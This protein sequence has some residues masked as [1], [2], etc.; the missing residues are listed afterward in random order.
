MGMDAYSCSYCIYIYFPVASTWEHRASAKR[1]VSLQFLNSKTVG[2]T[3]WTR[4]QPVARPPPTQTQNQR[5]HTSMPWVGF[6]STIPVLK[7]VQVVQALDRAATVIGTLY[8]IMDD[9]REK[10]GISDRDTSRW[11]VYEVEKFF[12]IFIATCRGLFVWLTGFGLDVG[13]INTLYTRL[14]LQATQRYRCST[15]CTRIIHRY[16]RTR[17]PSL[18]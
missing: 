15:H 16:T 11:V 5:R 4:D 3:P 10:D 12:P 14:G 1:F 8:C 13:F 9:N 18:Q 17:V 2:R 6:E 7:R